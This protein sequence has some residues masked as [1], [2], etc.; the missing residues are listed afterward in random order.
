MKTAAKIKVPQPCSQNWNKMPIQDQGRFCK[1]C[2]HVV[3]DFTRM[4][5]EEVVRF[6]VQHKNEKV[7]GHFRNDQLSRLKITVTPAQLQSVNWTV[8]QQV[9]IAIFLVFA[10][11]LFSCT[12]TDSKQQAPE[13]VIEKSD[14]IDLKSSD[15][16]IPHSVQLQDTLRNKNKKRSVKI[17]DNE[18]EVISG[19]PE[20]YEVTSGAPMLEVEV[21]TIN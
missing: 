5:D 18:I 17:Q 7:C 15:N 8:L 10:S 1:H 14:S 16:S 3:T 6:L 13:I 2:S 20:I 21:D 11:T 12:P 9:R 4:S 19:E